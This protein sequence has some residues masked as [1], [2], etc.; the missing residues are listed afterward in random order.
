MRVMRDKY[1]V[2][3]V[4]YGV[5]RA[6][7]EDHSAHILTRMGENLAIVQKNA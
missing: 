4:G 1:A 5:E 6:G 7:Q 3:M 2:P